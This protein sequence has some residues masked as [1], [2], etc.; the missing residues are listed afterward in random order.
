MARFNERLL[1]AA[2]IVLADL[3]VFFAPLAGLVIAYV[4]VAR[5]PWFRR[6]VDALYADTVDG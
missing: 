5:P 2:A 4:V 3:V 6:W 1:L